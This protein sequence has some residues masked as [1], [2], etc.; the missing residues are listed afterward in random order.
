MY[1]ICYGLFTSLSHW[2]GG[3]QIIIS[4]P[5]DPVQIL[6]PQ[7]VWAVHC[8]EKEDIRVAIKVGGRENRH[9]F[10]SIWISPIFYYYFSHIV[11]CEIVC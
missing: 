3:V 8:D 9:W 10:Q 2:R 4:L 1:H 5:Q 6:P 7:K 11:S